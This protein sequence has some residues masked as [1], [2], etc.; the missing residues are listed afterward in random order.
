M[1]LKSSYYQAEPY[2]AKDGSSIRE[3]MHPL[4]H[5]NLSL[6]MAEAIVMPGCETLRHR[7]TSSEEIYHINAGP[8]IRQWEK[9]TFM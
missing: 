5:G 4:V 8:D 9:T 6:N 1:L 2:I 3:P 7:H